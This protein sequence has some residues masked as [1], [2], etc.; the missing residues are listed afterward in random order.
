MNAI[1][2]FA[3]LLSTDTEDP[4]AINHVRAV[5]HILSSGNHLL[6]LVTQV[7][8]LNSLERGELSLRLDRVDP[9]RIIAD[10]TD[11]ISANAAAHDIH[12]EITGAGQATPPAVLADSV[13]ANQ[14]LLNLLSN[15]VKYNTSGEHVSVQVRATDDGFVR[16]TVQDDGPGIPAALHNK[17][18]QPFSRLGMEGKG[19]DGTG[20]GLTISKEIVNL[21][22]G[23]IGFESTEGVGSTFWFELPIWVEPTHAGQTT[24]N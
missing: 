18:F 14:V 15:A 9:T 23:R 4:L 7:L 13:S 19:I 24:I 8:D 10:C 12:I 11:I 22:D 6:E 20:I 1:L 21:M 17:I 2:G 5:Q 3:Q 16:L